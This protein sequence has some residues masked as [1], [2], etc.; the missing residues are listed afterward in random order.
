MP[1]I[2]FAVQEQY[3]FKLKNKTAIKNWL[4]NAT[5][6]HKCKAGNL[7]YIFCDDAFLLKI[8]KQFLNHNTYTDII[9]FDYC[10]LDK[11]T[12]IIS[13]EI[14][15]S[16]D[17]IKENAT[18]YGTTFDNELLRVMAHGL[19]HLIG[20]KDKSPAH[21]KEMTKKENELLANYKHT[22]K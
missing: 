8:N 20:F 15:I 4:L 7:A 16:I 19:L 13:G 22:K 21:K 3:S 12:K 5:V 17:R 9:T 14:Y 18:K 10:E 2:T 11:K 6:K 1:A